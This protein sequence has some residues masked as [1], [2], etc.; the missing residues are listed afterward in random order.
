MR[1][2][3]HRQPMRL[4]ERQ[5]LLR[6]LLRMRHRLLKRRPRRLRPQ[7][8]RLLPS[9]HLLLRRLLHLPKRLRPRPRRSPLLRQQQSP[10]QERSRRLWRARP[11]SP[12]LPRP[13]PPKVKQL[14]SR[15]LRVLRR[16][17][18]GSW[19]LGQIPLPL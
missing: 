1:P 16:A 9:L 15:R 4:L 10:P 8:R 5:Y 3:R 13:R 14:P 2:Q 12:L 19:V 11:R 17:R 7:N 18:L 6:R